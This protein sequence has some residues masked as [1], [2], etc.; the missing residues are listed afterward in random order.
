MIVTCLDCQQ[1]NR[2]PEVPRPD[3]DYRCAKCGVRLL[4]IGDGL[5]DKGAMNILRTMF[6]GKPYDS[7][8]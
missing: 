5:L 2:V 6:G 3:G 1:K 4:L 7:E 8:K